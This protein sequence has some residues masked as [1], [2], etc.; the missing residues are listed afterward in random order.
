MDDELLGEV[1]YTGLFSCLVI[2][3][4]ANGETFSRKNF[5]GSFFRANPLWGELLCKREPNNAQDSYAVAIIKVEILR[6]YAI[7]GAI[8]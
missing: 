4:F 8:N 5:R 3:K 7:L 6:Q 2:Q 1:P